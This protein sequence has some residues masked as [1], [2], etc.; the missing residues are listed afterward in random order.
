M[1]LTVIYIT[2]ITKLRQVTVVA[3]SCDY[4]FLTSNINT[5]NINTY[6]HEKQIMYTTDTVKALWLNF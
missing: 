1:I 5:V 4:V 2:Y 6:Q 3:I